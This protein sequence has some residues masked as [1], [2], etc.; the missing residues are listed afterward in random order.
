MSRIEAVE[1]AAT[2][3]RDLAVDLELTN[4]E[5]LSVVDFLSEA[6]RE[7]ELILLADVLGVSRVVDDQTHSGRGGT[8]S[9]VLGP[10][11]LPD[12]PWIDN[13]GSVVRSPDTGVP[14]A[15]VGTVADR[16]STKPIKD[17]IV[18]I[19]QADG[20]GRYS[21]ES[22]DVDRWHLRGRQR[23]GSDGGTESTRSVRST[24]R[25]STTVR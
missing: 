13:P 22:S 15:L 19:W 24:T 9:N 11:Y 7:G 12:A 5:L 4:D 3:L 25:S 10:F 14:L 18:D 6:A 20:S 16:A 23:T 17:A 2:A 21:N 8:A 1:R